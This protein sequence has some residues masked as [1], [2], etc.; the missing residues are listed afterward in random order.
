MLVLLLSGFWA[1]HRD[2]G[3]R[4]AGITTE[5]AA[6]LTFF[7][8]VLVVLGAMAVSIALAIVILVVL[9]KKQTLSEFRR[10]IQRYELEAAL[11]LLII[12]FIILPVLPREPLLLNFVQHVSPGVTGLHLAPYGSG[13]TVIV[14]ID[15]SNPGEP[16]N[17]A[18]AAFTAH[19]NVKWCIVVDSDVDIYDPAD[20]MWALS[21][22]VDWSQ[23]IFLVPGAQGHEMDPT[24]NTRGVHTKIGVDATADKG[25]REPASRVRYPEVNLSEYLA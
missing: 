2:G 22:R 17:V 23:D 5:I 15:K 1:I 7:L 8:G 4:E 9:A 14:A 21:T 20:V 11:K 6:V 18:M 16:R 12:T 24:S 13:F 10:H 25:R 3:G 19:I